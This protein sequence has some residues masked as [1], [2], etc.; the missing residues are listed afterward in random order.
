MNK[1]RC[2][3]P[4]GDYIP[5]LCE[6]FVSSLHLRDKKHQNT[7]TIYIYRYIVT[8]LFTYIHVVFSRRCSLKVLALHISVKL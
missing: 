7:Y 3:T 4:V 8:Y 2:V 1:T 6:R 5:H